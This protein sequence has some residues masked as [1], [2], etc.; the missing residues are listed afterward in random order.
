MPTAHLICGPLGSGKTTF[1][2]RL[3]SEISALRFTHDEWM[4]ILCGQDPPLG[5]FPDYFQRVTTLINS[6]WPRSL[7]LGLDVILDLNFWR[8]SQRDEV[9]RMVAAR[10]GTSTLYWLG[11]RKEVAW[12]RVKNRNGNSTDLCITPETFESLWPQ[13]EPLGLDEEHVV[14]SI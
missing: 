4:V 13:I 8:R 10:G 11:S 12:E 3:E 1:A 5:Q 2:R 14:I 7:E 9:R 6:I